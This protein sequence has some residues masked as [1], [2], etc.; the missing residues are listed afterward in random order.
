MIQTVL[1]SWFSG[2]NPVTAAWISLVVVERT[3]GAGDLL[4]PHVRC[5]ERCRQ[6]GEVGFLR[7]GVGAD[8]NPVGA[9]PD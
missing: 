6:R 3:L 5:A 2:S 4:E 9:E 1:P 8:Q 7:D